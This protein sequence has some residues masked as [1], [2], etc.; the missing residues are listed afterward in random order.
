M[1]KSELENQT[2]SKLTFTDNDMLILWLGNNDIQINDPPQ[3]AE[4]FTKYKNNITNLIDK[5]QLK[6]ITLI[7]LINLPE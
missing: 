5:Y 6:H 4:V 7:N 3:L 2:P 1:V